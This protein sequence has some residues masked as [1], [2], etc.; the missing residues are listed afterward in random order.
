M[1]LFCLLALFAGC[2]CF[3]SCGSLPKDC[4]GKYGG[5]MPAYTITLNGN[6]LLIAKHDVYIEITEGLI[7][8]VGGDLRL[9][10]T[11][12]YYKQ[13]KREYLIKTELS[14][15]KT[16]HYQISLIWNKADKKLYLTPQNGQSEAVLEPLN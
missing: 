7:K 12:A 3:L 4:Y 5:E 9:K 1:R 15:G 13:N 10:G 11:Y 2:S 14:N 8:Y 16:I 6:S